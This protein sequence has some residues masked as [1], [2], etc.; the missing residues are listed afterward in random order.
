MICYIDK[1]LDSLLIEEDGATKFE[2]KEILD[3]YS[4]YYK[5]IETCEDY[6]YIK[7]L[8][9]KIT[10]DEFQMQEFFSEIVQRY[11]PL[12]EI[13]YRNMGHQDF[14]I[15]LWMAEPEPWCDCDYRD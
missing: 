8:E 3:K 10:L 5:I 13:S 11:I 15:S 6:F 7:I 2:L 14:C 4:V 1:P 12:I 9:Q